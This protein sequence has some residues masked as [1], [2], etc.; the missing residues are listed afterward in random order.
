MSRWVGLVLWL[1]PRPWRVRYGSEFAALLE[2]SGLP[3]KDVPDIVLGAIQMQIKNW[4]FARTVA[5][6]AVA[7]ALV[8]LAGC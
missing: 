4:T 2:D 5:V 7:G 6:F 8:G 3:L 1:Y